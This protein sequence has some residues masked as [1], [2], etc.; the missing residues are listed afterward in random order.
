MPLPGATGTLDPA[1]GPGYA[2]ASMNPSTGEPRLLS[3]PAGRALAILTAINLLN[4]LDRFVVS[5]LF[6]SL[7]A[8]LWLTDARLGSLGTVFI[9]VYGLASPLFGIAGD[10]R[11]RPPLLALGVGLWSLAAMLSGAARGYWTLL[12]A[13]AAVGIGEAAYGTISPGLLADHFGPSRRSRA[14][15]VF[16]A[17]I[18]VGVALGYIVGGLVD[19]RLGWRWAFLIS[20]VPG[21]V[22]ALSCL[23]LR[24]PPRGASEST[25]VIRGEGGIAATYRRLLS[26]R[27]YALAVLGYAAY[28]FAVGGM[29]FWMPAF[30]ERTRGV[31]RSVATV[32]FGAIVVM[33]GFAGTFAGG[34]LADALRRRFREA[35]LWLC[36]ITT[37]A[38]APLALV[39]FMTYRPI[40]YLVALVLAQL[41]LFA[42]TGPVNAAIVNAVAPAERAS[43]V[44]ISILAIHLLGDVP[45]PWL[46]GIISDRSSL[47]RAVLIVPAAILVSGI[48]WTWAA[49][50][51]ERAARAARNGDQA[52][53]AAS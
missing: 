29:A 21:L 13:R 12:A 45:S 35:D 47:G 48:I 43:A 5:A 53:S 24:D 2:P 37:L 15:A 28:T 36:G 49:W 9:I 19:R 7:R 10:R 22:L 6:E 27:P 40:L 44:A 38:A 51:G 34:Y 52:R 16:F 39:V 3:G 18:P 14:Y 42:S 32:Q 26:N 11:P 46:I 31:P 50:R 20:G 41:L 23:R 17:A 33:T 4:Y 1:T 25:W 8:D 30:L